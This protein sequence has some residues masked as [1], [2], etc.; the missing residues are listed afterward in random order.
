MIINFHAFAA[1]SNSPQNVTSVSLS[2]TSIQ[3]IWGEVPLTDRNGEIILYE[4]RYEPQ[5]DSGKLPSQTENTTNLYLPLLDLQPFVVYAISVRAY[6]SVGH[7][8]YS[9]VSFVMTQEDG[10]HIAIVTHNNVNIH[11]NEIV[12]H[13]H[14]FRICF[15]F[16]VCI[17]QSELLYN[18][19]TKCSN[20]H[21]THQNCII[22]R[23]HQLV[24]T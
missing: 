12:D 9:S 15:Q 17:P 6:T 1:P 4:V 23:H 3:V 21:Y 2:S 11:I 16:P 18:Y 8:P 20:R 14:E 5:Q 7:G 10:K 19:S 22:L 13:S 24:S